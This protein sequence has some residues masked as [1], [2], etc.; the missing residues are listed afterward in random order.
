MKPKTKGV[1]GVVAFVLGIVLV[2]A[3]IF[4]IQWFTAEPRGAL[5]ARERTVADGSYRIAAYDKFFR[6]CSS[7]QTVQQNLANAQERADT[8]TDP[9]M[10]PQL[11]ANVNALS[12]TLNGAVNRYNADSAR[13]YTVAQ[14]KDSSLPFTLNAD[15]EIRCVL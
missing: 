15:Q 1:L 14:F 10:Q 4:A 11:D 7:A 3:V 9:A 2:A 12:N 6:D 13:D 8:N 5:D